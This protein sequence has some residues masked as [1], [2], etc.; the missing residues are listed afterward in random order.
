MFS[1]HWS[2]RLGPAVHLLRRWHADES[3]LLVLEVWMV[4]IWLISHVSML[5]TCRLPHWAAAPTHSGRKLTAM[6]HLL[7]GETHRSVI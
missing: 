2:L 3:C 7:I 1:P 5:E 6:T 4:E